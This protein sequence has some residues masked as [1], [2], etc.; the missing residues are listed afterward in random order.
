MILLPPLL[1]LP[2]LF[3]SLLLLLLLLYLISK[4]SI[5]ICLFD[6]EYT[7]SNIFFLALVVTIFV[8]MIIFHLDYLYSFLPDFLTS[9]L[10]L[11]YQ[12]IYKSDSE[13]DRIA[14]LFRTLQMF[15]IS[16][17]VA[18]TLPWHYEFWLPC[19]FDIVSY[20]SLSY[21]SPPHHGVTL[22]ILECVQQA[23]MIVLLYLM[24]SLP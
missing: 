6:H 14:F 12:P 3:F 13:L 16:P 2:L 19:P 8:Q 9:C 18:Q 22:L 10:A 15:L 1:L 20:Y 4:P 21:Q 5:K 11:Y 24:F 7:Q 23:L 17:E